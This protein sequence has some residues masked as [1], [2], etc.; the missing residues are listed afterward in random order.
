MTKI[1]FK[2]SG[3]ILGQELETD[4]D[5]NQLPDSESQE[6]MQLLT[7][8]NFFRIP[9]NL[10]NQAIPDEYEYTIAV[11]AGNT[12]HTVHTSDATA[13]E[14]LRPLVEK[15]TTVAKQGNSDK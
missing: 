14:A 13:P 4:I 9:Q 6:L 1:H 10:I 5:L 12:Q 2:R 3:G 15:L 11:E 7:Q 8:T